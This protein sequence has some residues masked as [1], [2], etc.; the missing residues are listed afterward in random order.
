MD[1]IPDLDDK[2]KE[3]EFFFD[4]LSVETDRNRFRWLVS[5]F[6]NAA[7]S[8]F[9]SS[10]LT[11]YFRF[12]DPESGDF[13]E[14]QQGLAALRKHVRVS[15]NA[16][17]PNYVKTSGLGPL[18]MELYDFRKKSTHH[19]PLSIMAVGP[20]LPQDFQFGSMRGQGRPV[21]PLCTEAMQ[22]IRAVHSE[23]NT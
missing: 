4:A 14:D 12:T 1:A 22:L 10:A 11:A 23:I 19:N 16:K 8:F 2:V 13:L 15:Q 17:N 7:Y 21:V 6:L 5:A 20:T 9:E 3:C 18:T